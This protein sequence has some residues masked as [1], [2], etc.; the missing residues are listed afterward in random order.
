MLVG[1]FQCEQISGVGFTWWASGIKS[2]MK[3]GSDSEFSDRISM[4]LTELGWN[5]GLLN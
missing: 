1:R 5:V 4:Y 3:G 2:S